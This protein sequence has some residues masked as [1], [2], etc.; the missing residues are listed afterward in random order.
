MQLKCAFEGLP[1]PAITWSFSEGNILPSMSTIGVN[2]N[3]TVLTLMDLTGGNTGIYT[4]SASNVVG[5]S[6]A[7]TQLF[8][9]GMFLFSVSQYTKVD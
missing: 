8:V 2:L 4:C 5:N 9:Q 6:A 3:V 7:S 1:V